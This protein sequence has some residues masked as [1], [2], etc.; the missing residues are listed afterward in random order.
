MVWPSIV[1]CV[2]AVETVKVPPME[3][4]IMD[5]YVDRHENQEKEEENRLLV[6]MH[7]NFPEG[8][9]CVLVPSVWMWPLA[10]WCESVC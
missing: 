6:K 8:Y 3:E 2:I 9:G 4:V 1:R 10:Q 5:A 7:P